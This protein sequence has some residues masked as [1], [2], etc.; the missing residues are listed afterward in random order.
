[1]SAIKLK[2]VKPQTAK[3]SKAKV[4]IF[5]KP[6]VGKTWGALDFPACFYVDSEGGAN[7]AHYTEKLEK[8]GGIYFGPDEGS[9]DFAAVIEQ[10][11][12][13]ATVKH[14]YKTLVI[15]SLSKLFHNEITKEAERL[16]DKDAFG[17]SKKPAMRM[18]ARLMYWVDK[19]DMTVIVV[20]HE[21]AE[22]SK[23]EQIG[24]V[25]DASDKLG[26]ELNLCL[27]IIKT[28]DS[29]KA[30]IKK[31]RLTGFPDSASFEWNYE[32]FAKRYGKDIMERPVEP[33]ILATSEQIATV[34]S[35]L[36]N[37]KLT[38]STKDKW[39]ADN[40]DNLA[41]IEAEKVD[42]VIK[43]L[44]AKI[45]PPAATVVPPKKEKLL[46]TPVPTPTPTI[47][48]DEIL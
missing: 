3:P 46:P 42:G 26:Y 6:G 40:V 37:I 36:E 44:Q 22:W 23:G 32:E 38:D 11:Q 48:K 24:T 29:R 43:H 15:D 19:L 35:L 18:S 1:M 5:G 25:P 47:E 7:L 8:S 14:P 12:A 39:I 33:I 21:K 4:A 30:L 10:V 17:A 20:T 41:D 16:G 28:G 34:K 9:T 2:G 13:L 45:A 27:Q 31:T